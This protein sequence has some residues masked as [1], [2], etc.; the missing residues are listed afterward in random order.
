MEAGE[1]DEISTT[2]YK[3]SLKSQQG[4]MSDVECGVSCS[5]SPS[6]WF[7][8]QYAYFPQ[9]YGGCWGYCVV[10]PSTMGG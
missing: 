8:R 1:L 2:I 4:R 6:T 7:P 3:F 5:S 9:P 10:L